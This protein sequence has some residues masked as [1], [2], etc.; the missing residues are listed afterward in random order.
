MIE[1]RTS[2]PGHANCI[3]NSQLLANPSEYRVGNLYNRGYADT[4]NE[5]T[6]Q[7]LSALVEIKGW[8]LLYVYPMSILRPDEHKRK[9]DCLHYKLP[10]P[11]D[12]WNHLL[13]SSLTEKY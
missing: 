13:Y 5:Y 3:E 8:M 1:F 7:K 2:V 4:Y 11:P 6:K 10:G 12:F 9:E